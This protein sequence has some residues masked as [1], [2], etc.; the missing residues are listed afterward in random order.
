M[1]HHMET[2][3]VQA[4][5]GLPMEELGFVSDLCQGSC[6]PVQLYQHKPTGTPLVV[7]V[8]PVVLN[9]TQQSDVIL[10]LSRLYNS[11]HPNITRFYGVSY[12]A[13]GNNISLGLEYCEARPSVDWL[14]PALAR[15]FWPDHPHCCLDLAGGLSRGRVS[16]SWAHS[17]ASSRKDCRTCFA[18]PKLSSQVPFLFHPHARTWLHHARARANT[19]CPVPLHLRASSLVLNG[20]CAES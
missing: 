17:R 13:A 6:G 9:E 8:I 15:A 20:C 12:Q 10:Q 16:D 11:D 1:A 3:P 2:D 4:H 7:K 5:P 14:P 18:W 19:R